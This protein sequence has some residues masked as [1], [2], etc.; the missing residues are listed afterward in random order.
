MLIE[1]GAEMFN[2]CTTQLEN[3]IEAFL[4]LDKDLAEMVI[5]MEYKMNALDLKIDRDW[6][7]F[8]V[9]HKP[10]AGDLRFLLALRKIN[11][12]L[13]S[14]GDYAYGISKFTSELN[15]VPDRR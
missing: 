8:L 7:Q 14:I 1:L 15:L 11:F 10:V 5:H 2:P 12:D 6:E 4:S 3:S 9:L 13:E